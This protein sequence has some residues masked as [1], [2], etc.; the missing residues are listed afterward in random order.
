LKQIKKIISLPLNEKLLLSEAFFALILFYFVVNLLPLKYYSRF[1]GKY[2][3]KSELIC[4]NESQYKAICKALKR[5]KKAIPFHIKC[6]VSSVALKKMLDRRN[7]SSTLFLG[8][9]K[10]ENKEL[11]AHAWVCFN[12]YNN[13]NI[14]FKIIAFYT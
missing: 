13:N 14:S 10:T 3:Q 1:V 4:S 8:L 12:E 9:Q 7:V 11:K 2:M 6:M 5:A